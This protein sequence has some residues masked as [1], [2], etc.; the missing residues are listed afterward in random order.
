[1]GLAARTTLIFAALIF[2]PITC[3]MVSQYH[4]HAGDKP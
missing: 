4:S 3:M 1:M 2:W